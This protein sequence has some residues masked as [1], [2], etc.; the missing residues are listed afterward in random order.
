M[1]SLVFLAASLT[2]VAL[3]SLQVRIKLRFNLGVR[4]RFFW[5]G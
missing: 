2:G 4:V 1:A 5:V 3:I